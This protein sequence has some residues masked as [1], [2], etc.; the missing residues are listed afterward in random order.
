M[1]DLY[2]MVYSFQSDFSVKDAGIN[3]FIC[4]IL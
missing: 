2:I 1:G 4:K 3:V